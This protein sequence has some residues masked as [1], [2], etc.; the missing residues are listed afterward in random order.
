MKILKQQKKAYH[1]PY[2]KCFHHIT[3]EQILAGSPPT[4]GAGSPDSGTG[5]GTPGNFPITTKQTSFFFEEEKEE[6]D[7]ES[8]YYW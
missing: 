1:A 6:G 4:G 5:D 3:A 8:G 7:E 2:L